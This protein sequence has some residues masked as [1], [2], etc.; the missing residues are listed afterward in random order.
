MYNADTDVERE[1]IILEEL[2][3]RLLVHNEPIST[4]VED[5][6]SIVTFERSKSF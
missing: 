5:N 2:V 3:N 4:W 1:S 6:K